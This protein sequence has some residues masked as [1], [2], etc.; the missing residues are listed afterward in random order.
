MVL[1]DRLITRPSKYYEFLKVGGYKMLEAKYWGKL[2]TEINGNQ[3]NLMNLTPP[4]K[5][6]SIGC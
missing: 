2:P 3:Y 1:P 4:R 5:T 6:K